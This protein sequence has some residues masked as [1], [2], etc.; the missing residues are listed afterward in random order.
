MYI[1]SDYIIWWYSAG[2]VVLF[3]YLKSFQILLLDSFS[4]GIILSSFFKPWKKDA[5]P[6]SG[7]SIDQKLKVLIFNLISVGFGMVVKTIVLFVYSITLLLLLAMELL[8]III[9][10]ITPLLVVELL[11]LG[12][13]HLTR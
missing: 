8:S 1:V 7:L 12:L 6:T 9:W 13:I 5:T 2:I 10:I 11:I 4:V 3:K